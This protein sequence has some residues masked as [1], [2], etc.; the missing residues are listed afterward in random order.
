PTRLTL[1]L[2][3]GILGACGGGGSGSPPPPPPP[4]AAPIAVSLTTGE[5]YV[6]PGTGIGLSAAVSNDASNQGVK[7]SVTCATSPG[8][9]GPP[10]ATASGATPTSTAPA[11][12]PPADLAVTVT[13]TSVADPSATAS[14]S[15]TVAGGIVITITM[16]SP[17]TGD[18]PTETSVT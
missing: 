4:P 1:V 2:L 10:E 5:T 15:V 16:V 3:H 6:Q 7:W 17:S 14:I 11:A 13:A 8:G 9:S 12:R 18:I